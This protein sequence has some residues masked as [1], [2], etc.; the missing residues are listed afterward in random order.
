MIDIIKTLKEAKKYRYSRW[1]GNP[2]GYKYEEGYCVYEV[3]DNWLFRQCNR[4]NGYGIN[5]LYCKQHSKIIN[6]MES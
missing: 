4:K 3:F 5:G 2:N 1:A 6:I